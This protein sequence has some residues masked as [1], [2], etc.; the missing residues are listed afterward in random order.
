M[1]RRH[2]GSGALVGHGVLTDCPD[3]SAFRLRGAGEDGW[4]AVTVEAAGRSMRAI[5]LR[6]GI[7]GR[8]LVAAR[9]LRAGMLLTEEDL[10]DEP[11]LRW[12][13]PASHRSAG[14]RSGVGRP[15]DYRAG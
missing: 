7:A 2:R 13:P 1:G 4:F 6:A 9:A 11:H 10:R 12:G 14:A 3:T 15:A 5:R 8:R